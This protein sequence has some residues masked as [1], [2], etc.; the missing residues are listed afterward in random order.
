M[1]KTVLSV[2]GGGVRGAASARF[3]RRVD[4]RLRGKFNTTIRDRVDFFAGTSTG[5]FIALALATTGLTMKQI[6]QLYNR[7]NAV[8]I[9]TE[10]KGWLE[11][12]GLNAPKYEGSRKT[13]LLKESFGETRTLGSLHQNKHV[14]V[15]TY[16]VE[17]REP[18]VIK[19]TKN[20]H[21]DLKVYQIA[22]ASSAAPTYF[23]TVGL[24][25][26]NKQKWLIDGGV[27]V[28]NPT[29]CAISEVL[30]FWKDT[31]LRDINVLSLGTGT[32]TRKIIDGKA[33]REWGI[34]GWVK[35]GQILNILSDERIVGYQAKTILSSGNY[36]R[37]NAELATQTG[38]EAIPSDDM[39]D[40]ESQNIKSLRKFGEFLYSRY[41]TPVVEM[42]MGKYQGSSLDQL[43]PS[44]GQPTIVP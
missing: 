40:V 15:S 11:I 17:K 39:D 28:N 41:G 24:Q 12:D 25:Y 31:D 20:S 1:T 3:L 34:L 23:P 10:N 14:L 2:D 4:E 27:V 8:R 19:S 44:N 37:V 7:K 38:L 30:S 32:K 9:F 22:D 6:D 35:K 36:I 18:W 29:M 43:D 5:S 33:S 16:D 26:R 21:L 13:N 42:L